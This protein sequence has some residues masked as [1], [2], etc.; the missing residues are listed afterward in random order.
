MFCEP[1]LVVRKDVGE[2]FEFGAKARV[3]EFLS[4]GAERAGAGAMFAD[5]APQCAEF[6]GEA[7]A[8]GAGFVNAEGFAATTKDRAQ[9][10]DAAFFVEEFGRNCAGRVE[11]ELGEALEGEDAQTRK[12][13]DAFEGEN[14]TLKLVGGLAGRD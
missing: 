13:V 14:L 1:R 5:F 6:L 9:G 12:A 11:D 7:F 4:S 2:V 10:H 8:L 3:I